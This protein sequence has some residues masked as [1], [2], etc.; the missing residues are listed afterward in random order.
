MKQIKYN[1]LPEVLTAEIVAILMDMEKQQTS[2]WRELYRSMSFDEKNK[3]Y[4]LKNIREKELLQKEKAEKEKNI[5]QEDSDNAFRSFWVRYV[6][7]DKHHSD[8]TFEE[9]L[10]VTMDKAFYTPEKIKELYSNKV[11]NRILFRREY[12]NNEELF[13]FFWATKSP[14]S[15]WHS[16]HFKA[17]TFIGAANEEAVEKLLA[18][19]F[20][21]SEQR[22][23]SAEQFM[24]YHKAML[25]LD[26]TTAKQ[27]MS[28]NDVRNIKELGRQVKHFD[29]NV[30]KYHRSNIVYEGNKAKFTQNEALKEALLATQ[31]TTLVEAA[32]NDTIWGIGLTQD[33]VGAQRR[34]TWSGK[35]LLGEI[36]TQIRV[37]LMGEY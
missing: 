9:E 13:T 35:N 2:E 33:D 30:W 27:I 28:T 18:G 22:Y 3:Y 16:A 12:L 5:T 21:V 20:P 19:A 15:Q 26:R 29:E 14:F 32:P 36:L 1:E 7:L 4:E 37:E 10:E 8:I 11:V 24:M 23:S 6:N 31:G 34:E 17:T 25:F